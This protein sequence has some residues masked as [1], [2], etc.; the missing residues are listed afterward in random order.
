MESIDVRNERQIELSTNI[1]AAMKADNEEAMAKAFADFTK[2]IEEKVLA[3]ANQL[4][5]EVNAQV[6]AARGVR[7]LTSAETNY[8][9]KV[10]NAL[11]ADT[12]GNAK[13]SLN[14]D[15][16]RMPETIIEQ[17]LGDVTT[18]HPLLEVINFT[19]TSLLTSWD[20]NVQGPQ[21]AIWG[22]IT[23]EITKELNGEVT[24]EQI[25]LTKL[26]AFFPVSIG[27]L[28]LGPAWIDRYIREILVEAIALG[29]ENAIIDGTGLKQPIGMTRDLDEDISQTTGYARKTA[30]AVTEFT[31]KKYGALVAELAIDRNGK[32]RNIN[33]LILVVNPLDYYT[34]VMPATVRQT[35]DGGYINDVFPI[36]TKV[37]TAA[38]VTRGEAILGLADNYWFGI[39]AGTNGGKIE[40]AD[41][42]KWLED[43]RYYKTRMYGSGRPVD[44][45]SFMLLD[46]SGLKEYVR[47]VKTVT[48]TE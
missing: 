5:D 42:Y 47:R 10:I 45:T 23:A 20:V 21:A 9:N 41:E 4:K 2:S 1:A 32:S 26:S 31:P 44:N 18:K 8:Y 11:R 37:I 38:G 12:S 25:T 39:G 28:D 15:N 27:M 19:N 36:A 6:L 14:T 7:C 16:M 48:D 34:L 43:K 29:A 24:S 3:D 22:D 30:V 46:I 40:Y 17:I 35:M 33:N 13:M